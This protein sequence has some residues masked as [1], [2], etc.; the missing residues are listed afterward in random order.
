[1]RSNF[2]SVLLL[3]Q[4]SYQKTWMDVTSVEASL[5][6]LVQP[7]KLKQVKLYQ[8]WKEGKVQIYMKR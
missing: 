8:Q 6:H 3:P 2:P 5:S 4:V 1:M 7:H